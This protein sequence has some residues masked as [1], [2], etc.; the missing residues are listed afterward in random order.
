MKDLGFPFHPFQGGG[1]CVLADGC[2]VTSEQIQ[3]E[4]QATLSPEEKNRLFP[5]GSTDGFAIE[6]WDFV[7]AIAT[8]RKPEMDGVDGLRAK[9]LCET[10]YESAT[11]GGFVRFDDVFEGHVDAYQRPIDAYWQI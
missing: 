4:Y 11:A 2:V 6:V 8:G 10:C 5:Y 9:T 3:A 1:E 7:N